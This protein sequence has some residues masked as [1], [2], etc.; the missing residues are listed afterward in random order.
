MGVNVHAV[1][2]WSLFGAFGWNKLLTSQPRDYEAG[3][4][5]VQ[6]DTPRIT[7]I[8]QF[9][10]NVTGGEKLHPLSQQR[11]WWRQPSRFHIKETMENVLQ[12]NFG[13]NRM[14]V[15]IGKTGTLGSAF[16]KICKQRNIPFILTGRD[17]LDIT[18][19]KN[20]SLSTLGN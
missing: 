11:G 10:K 7:A 20:R 6:G 5:D 13:H 17:T 19:G 2:F 1:T 8:G 18:N 16:A 4:F 9:I 3:A 14:V 15:I 12:N